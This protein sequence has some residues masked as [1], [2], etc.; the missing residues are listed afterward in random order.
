MKRRW[1]VSV[2]LRRGY[3]FKNFSEL[4]FVYMK[5]KNY[6]NKRMAFSDF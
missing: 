5:K 6:G 1:A 2:T 4:V 3:N